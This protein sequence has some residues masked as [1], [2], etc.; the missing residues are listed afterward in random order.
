VRKVC[1]KVCETSMWNWYVKLVWGRYR[2]LQH[3]T[4]TN[5]N[6][7]WYRNTTTVH[8]NDAPLN[9]KLIVRWVVYSIVDR[10]T[11]SRYQYVL[12]I[13]GAWKVSLDFMLLSIVFCIFILPCVWWCNLKVQ[14]CMIPISHMFLDC[15]YKIHIPSWSFFV[16]MHY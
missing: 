10:T 2:L 5:L 7:N 14:Y 8:I 13:I 9:S 3:V 11:L 12:L 1:E 16:S 4:E 15:Q 6:F